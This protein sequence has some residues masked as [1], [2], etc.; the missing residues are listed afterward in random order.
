MW[1]GVQVEVEEM[2]SRHRR[3]G[4]DDPFCEV[5]DDRRTVEDM[6]AELNKLT[7]TQKMIDLLG[8]DGS[9]YFEAQ[10][11]REFMVKVGYFLSSNDRCL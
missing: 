3:H 7:G 8:G 2:L 5:K 1:K 9:T 4:S 6:R 10:Q 11:R